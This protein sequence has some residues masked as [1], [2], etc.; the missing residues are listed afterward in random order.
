MRV[1]NS[2]RSEGWED[3]V[4]LLIM[5]TGAVFCWYVNDWYVNWFAIIAGI[6]AGVILVEKYEWTDRHPVAGF[7]VVVLFILVLVVSITT[8]SLVSGAVSALTAAT[9]IKVYEVYLYS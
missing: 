9:A 7:P 6:G 5:T 1:I 2:V 3:T 8:K 4:A